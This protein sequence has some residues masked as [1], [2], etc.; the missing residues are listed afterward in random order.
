M[1]TV[2]S[3]LRFPKDPKNTTVEKTNDPGPAT[4]ANYGT[5]G[6]MPKYQRNDAN[7]RVVALPPKKVDD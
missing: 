7:A 1:L 5:V 3:I 4:Y 2:Y 6:V